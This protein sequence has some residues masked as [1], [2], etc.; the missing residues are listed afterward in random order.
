VLGESSVHGDPYGPAYA[1]PAFLQQRLAAALPDSVVEVVNCGVPAVASWHVRLVAEEVVR[2]RPDVV[3]VYAGHNDFLVR[4]P[5][6]VGLVVRLARFRVTSSR[7][8]RAARG[9]G[10]G[11]S[12]RGGGGAGRAVPAGAR[13][14]R[15]HE[16]LTASEALP[17]RHLRDNLR[18]IFRPAR[19]AG[20]VPL[21]E[22]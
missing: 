2:Y 18:G 11:R 22:P 21:R 9:A 5:E 6:P 20:A 3:L 12:M 4:E 13:A 19:A 7:S 10:A 1:F 17:S 15:G 14:C 8:P 16:H